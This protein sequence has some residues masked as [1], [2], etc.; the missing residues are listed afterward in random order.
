MG[1]HRSASATTGG[2]TRRLRRRMVAAG[3]GVVMVAAVGGIALATDSGS[4]PSVYTPLPPTVVGQY[5]LAAGG[6]K[7]VPVAG[8]DGVPTSAT[9]VQLSVTALNESATSSLY[10]YAT[11]TTQPDSANLRWNAGAVTTVPI[12]TAVGTNGKIHLHNTTGT[13]QIKISVIG[14]YA[15]EL[16]STAI[17][18]TAFSTFLSTTAANVIAITVPTGTYSVIATLNLQQNA[19]SATAEDEVSCILYDP[20]LDDIDEGVQS[21]TAVH[22][23]VATLTMTGL[24]TM[25]AGQIAVSCDDSTSSALAYEMRLTAIHLSSASGDVAGA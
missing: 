15:P 11:G 1:L 18:K 10:L 7:D 17:G 23:D 4:V 22:G 9:S 6:N 2:S 21:L 13:A 3:A 14:Y 16:G 8:V 19:T 20:N 24:V 12:T 5:S 25:D